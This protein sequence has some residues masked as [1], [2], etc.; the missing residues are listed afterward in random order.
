MTC[1]TRDMSICINQ[2]YPRGSNLSLVCVTKG[3]MLLTLH[4][5][6]VNLKTVERKACNQNTG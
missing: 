3:V 4:N 6:L 1:L 5:K 2:F